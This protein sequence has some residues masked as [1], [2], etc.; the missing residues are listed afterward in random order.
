MKL[1]LSHRIRLWLY[2]RQAKALLRRAHRDNRP[3]RPSV[4]IGGSPEETPFGKPMIAAACVL[5]ALC[6]ALSLNALIG[7]S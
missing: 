2:T 1:R 6:L 3:Y 7:Q 5:C 4:H